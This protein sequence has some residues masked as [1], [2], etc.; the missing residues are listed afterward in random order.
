MD[1]GSLESDVNNQLAFKASR[2]ASL[3][4][5]D[6]TGTTGHGPGGASKQTSPDSN[7]CVIYTDSLIIGEVCAGI[8]IPNIKGSGTTS[9]S[10]HLCEPR[11][12]F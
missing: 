12:A 6:G 1:L 3:H 10:G 5:E 7:V 4:N 2:R 9:P 11:L 8:A